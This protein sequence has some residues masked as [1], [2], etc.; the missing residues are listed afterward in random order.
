VSERE[1]RG[2]KRPATPVEGVRIIGAEEAQAAVDAGSVAPRRGDDEVR[3]GD[4]PPAPQGP[5]PPLR[6]PL[7][8]DEDPAEVVRPQ[9]TPPAAGPGFAGGDL[10]HWT[11]PP[12]GENPRILL[13]DE[14]EED[15]A[16]W[17]APA[18]G[19]RWREEG[20]SDWDDVDTQDPSEWADDEAPLGALDTERPGGADLFTFDDEDEIIDLDEPP[21]VGPRTAQPRATS[22]SSGAPASPG[23]DVGTA[24]TTGV[25]VAAAFLLA[26]KVF[27][28]AGGAV[29]VTLVLGLASI[30]L[31]SALRQRGFRPATLLGIAGT[32]ALSWAA[33]ERGEQAF[34]LVM[35]LFVVFA[36]LWYLLGVV[37]S[38]PVGNMGASLLGF[39]YVGFLGAHATLLLR[40]DD[41]VGM[42]LGAIVATVG[43]DT[44][45]FFVGSQFGRTPLAAASPNKTVEG[46][47]GG[48]TGAIVASLV[49]LNFIG[50]HPWDGGSA[51]ALGLVVAVAAPLGDLC[52]S[53]VKR[54]LGIKD[55]GSILPGH[56]G[57]LD[58]I[59]AMLFVIPATY[60]LVKLLELY[61]R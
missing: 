34:P 56:G 30:E 25:I 48:M 38:Q 26:L 2:D 9:V 51:L 24:V 58:R 10:P 49:V 54:D 12:T 4:V 29:F 28:N 35:S 36:M 43:Y 32:V 57:V 59:D 5:R 22:P 14:D 46:L 6:F 13:G 19:P 61:T 52:E 17:V 50:V 47:L 31:F 44:G 21:P 8:G 27:E 3:Y 7:A 11:E 15:D 37:Q 45:G 42:L 18:S 1:E 41:G 40:F 60:Y 53:L 20:P 16:A 55:M 23:R 39:A 33:Y